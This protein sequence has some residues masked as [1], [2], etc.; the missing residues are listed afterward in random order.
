MVVHAEEW[1]LLS[2]QRVFCLLKLCTDILGYVQ[3]Y[4]AAPPSTGCGAHID[5]VIAPLKVNLHLHS[6]VYVEQRGCFCFQS[7]V[8]SIAVKVNRSFPVCSNK[9]LDFLQSVNWTHM[10]WQ[11]RF[12]DLSISARMKENNI[13]K[14]LSQV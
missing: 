6:S 9:D 14:K 10:C 12:K 1:L 2:L 8:E 5:L 13:A 7:L 11:S 3:L 4:S